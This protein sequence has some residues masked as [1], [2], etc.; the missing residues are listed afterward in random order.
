MSDQGRSASH[1]GQGSPE[2]PAEMPMPRMF[3][4]TESQAR[5]MV[6]LIV[7]VFLMAIAYGVLRGLG[8]GHLF[9]E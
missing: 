3:P 6:I 9:A 2:K 4:R 1:R 8:L 7:V 5:A